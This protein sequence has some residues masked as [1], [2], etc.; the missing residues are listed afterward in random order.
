MG[1]PAWYQ[2][3]SS[4]NSPLLRD[5]VPP[6]YVTLGIINLVLPLLCQKCSSSRC[7]ICLMKCDTDVRGDVTV[8]SK[9]AGIPL[10]RRC[11]HTP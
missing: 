4:H 8:K 1:K 11:G 7:D 5:A 9:A 10:M 6:K 3:P 2:Y